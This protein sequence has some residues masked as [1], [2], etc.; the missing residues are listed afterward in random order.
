[1]RLAAELSR[2][3]LLVTLFEAPCLLL[4]LHQQIAMQSQGI[5]LV[6]SMLIKINE[7]GVSLERKRDINIA[8]NECT[9]AYVI[10]SEFLN[11]PQIRVR[12]TLI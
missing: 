8:V 2:A 7:A 11:Y 5:L 4:P 12:G 3:P 1:M 9:A 6:M 10:K